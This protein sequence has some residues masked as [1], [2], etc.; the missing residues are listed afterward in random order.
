MQLAPTDLIVPSLHSEEVEFVLLKA[1]Q[2]RRS[3]V[4]DLS[5]PFSDVK[6]IRAPA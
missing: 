2:R 4:M 1:V 6:G 5:L 3:K